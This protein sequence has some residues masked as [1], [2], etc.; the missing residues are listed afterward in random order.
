MRKLLYIALAMVSVAGIY[1]CGDSN[2]DEPEPV[3]DPVE[4]ID[5]EV[6]LNDS[7]AKVAAVSEP[8]LEYGSTFA[9]ITAKESRKL[10][11]DTTWTI[12]IGLGGYE[13]SMTR[14]EI[15][16]EVKNDS[17][18]SFEV[19]YLFNGDRFTEA[20]MVVDRD[21]GKRLYSFMDHRYKYYGYDG[22]KDYYISKDTTDF[23]YVRDMTTINS[24]YDYYF[25]NYQSMSPEEWLDYHSAPK[26]NSGI[27]AVMPR[28]RPEF[29][30][31]KNK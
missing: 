17:A 16:Y 20:Y 5:P 13:G 21:L 22:G 3:I 2:N 29:R 28:V 27:E 14:R 15:H 12:N 8:I 19:I 7:L 25:V 10:I 24:A 1:S 30:N 9:E 23:V 18:L 31:H 11:Y 4:P 6:A 26:Q